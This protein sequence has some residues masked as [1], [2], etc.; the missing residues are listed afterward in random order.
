MELLANKLRPKCLND[1]IG[2]KH[3]IGD[4]KVLSNLVKNGKV[5]CFQKV[6]PH[7]SL[8]Q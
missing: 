4:N 7:F 2:Q 1:I 3:L 6:L 5:F 8:Q